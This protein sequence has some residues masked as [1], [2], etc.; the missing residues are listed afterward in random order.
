[1]QIQ[2]PRERQ[3]LQDLKLHAP[4]RDHQP[5][6]EDRHPTRRCCH[7]GQQGQG[8]HHALLPSRRVGRLP[9]WCEGGPVRAVVWRARTG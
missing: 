8:E 2:F 7:S 1:M 9:P 5:L 3:G 6:C 4:G